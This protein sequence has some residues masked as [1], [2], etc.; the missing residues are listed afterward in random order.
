[1]GA[2]GWNGVFVSAQSGPRKITTDAGDIVV[3]TAA[4]PATPPKRPQ[5]KS[6]INAKPEPPVEEPTSVVAI[7]NRMVQFYLSYPT[8]RW[9]EVLVVVCTNAFVFPLIYYCYKIN[10]PHAVI[11]GFGTFITSTFYHTGE[12][13][14]LKILGM[15]FGRWHRLDNIFIILSLQQIFFHLCMTCTPNHLAWADSETKSQST[16]DGLIFS[17]CFDVSQDLVADDFSG[18]PN[19]PGSYPSGSSLDEK[20]PHQNK[21]VK[22]EVCRV[23]LHQSKVYEWFQWA[24][25]FMTLVCQEIS[26][27]NEFFTFFPILVPAFLV[28]VRRLVF[29]ESHLCPRLKPSWLILGVISLLA[30]LGCFIKG[31]DDRND[32]LRIWHGMWHVFGSLGFFCLFFSKKPVDLISIHQAVHDKMVK[33]DQ[34]KYK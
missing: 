29:L 20:P 17:S 24:F 6:P 19:S 9:L 11:I 16:F 32:Y 28:I 5:P 26:P 25:L 18:S 7:Y 10:S 14:F 30:G 1:M 15:D 3:P 21:K 27:W 33:Q 2:S 23:L 22:S 34:K 13:L 12:T 4:K 8:D 31:L